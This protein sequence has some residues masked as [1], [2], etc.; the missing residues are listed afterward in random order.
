MADDPTTEGDDPIAKLIVESRSGGDEAFASLYAAVYTSLKQVARN[1]LSEKF[2]HNTISTT[3]LV[4]EA[5][6]KLMAG[7]RPRLED[8][9]HLLGITANAM[10][11]VLVDYARRSNA[12]KRP[13][14]QDRVAITGIDVAAEQ[15]VDVEALDEALTRLAA[16]DPQQANVV[17]LKFFGGMT[18]EDIAAALGISTATVTREWRLARGWLQRELDT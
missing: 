18:L 4:N 3:A 15:T 17:N 10:R 5:Y 8:R 9:A 7:E 12:A 16:I 1:R 11:Q 6:L 14:K 13:Q 2:G